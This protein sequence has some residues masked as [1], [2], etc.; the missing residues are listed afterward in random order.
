MLGGGAAYG[1]VR[2]RRWLIL[3]LCLALGACAP[4]RP[5]R[6][7]SGYIEAAV[8][9]GDSVSIETREGRS[10][11]IRVAAVEAGEIHGERGER[12][13]V[14]D[15]ESLSVRTW[16]QVRQPCGG[17]R[18]LGCSVPLPLAVASIYHDHYR[19]RFEQACIQHDFCYRHGYATYGRDR[20]SCDERFRQEMEAECE[21][22]KGGGSDA[23]VGGVDWFTQGATCRMA[24]SQFYAA[25]RR[26]GADAFHTDESTVCEYE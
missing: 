18:K 21:A 9:P 4:L 25:V 26:F 11:R 16:G 23:L 19:V 14:A 2:A 3:P 17:D 22:H 1:T 24:A 5:V 8:A 13:A 10:L 12:V 6:N 7:Q 15:I 20:D